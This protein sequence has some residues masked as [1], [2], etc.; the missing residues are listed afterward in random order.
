MGDGDH[1][2]MKEIQSQILFLEQQA[3]LG[4]EELNRMFVEHDAD[5]RMLLNQALTNQADAHSK[6]EQKLQER[7]RKRMMMETLGDKVHGH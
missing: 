7:K 6:L 5:T 4:E 1:S 3:Q 2:A